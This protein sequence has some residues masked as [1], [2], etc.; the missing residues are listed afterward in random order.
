MMIETLEV[1]DAGYPSE[2]ALEKIEALKDADP[3]EI[4]EFMRHRFVTCG[5]ELNHGKCEVS[6]DSGIMRVEF[7]TGGWSGCED[8]V[9]A[10]LSV[11]LVQLVYYAE[12]KRGGLHV[13]EVEAYPPSWRRWCVGPETGGC[14]CRGCVRHPTPSTVRG[15]PEY[16]PWPSP[17]DALT[18]EEFKL[19]W[20]TRAR[21]LVMGA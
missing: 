3:R 7:V 6:E 18:M 12:W 1:D 9:G 4:W 17:A 8:F 13:F 14:A 16:Q 21:A 15:D 19:Y 2:A 10:V 5:R 20:D 11:P